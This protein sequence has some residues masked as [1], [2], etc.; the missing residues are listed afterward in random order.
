M[1]A[2]GPL[3]DYRNRT[4]MVSGDRRGGSGIGY[5]FHGLTHDD[6][7]AVQ[8]AAPECPAL[9]V[10]DADVV[11]SA[12]KLPHLQVHRTLDDHRTQPLRSAVLRRRPWRLRL[13]TRQPRDDQQG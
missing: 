12:G 10:L 4:V 8:R 1:A 6:R 2:R 5:A 13:A 11:E 7:V 3:V 9:D